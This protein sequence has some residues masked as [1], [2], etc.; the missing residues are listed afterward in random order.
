MQPS[1]DAT[2]KWT[3]HVEEIF[4]MTLLPSG[5][6]VNS[7]YLGANIPGKPRRV[8]FYFGGAAGYFQE[9]QKSASDDFEGFEFAHIQAAAR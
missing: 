4:N 7:W 3:S 8:L 5:A 1:A 9:I 6:S 2:Q